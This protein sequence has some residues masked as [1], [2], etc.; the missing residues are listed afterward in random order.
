M[1]SGLSISDTEKRQG[2]E[3]IDGDSCVKGHSWT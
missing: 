1:M 3:S 2:R